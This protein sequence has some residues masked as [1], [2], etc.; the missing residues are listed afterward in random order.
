MAPPRNIRLPNFGWLPRLGLLGRFSVL[1]LAAF[2]LIGIVLGRTLTDQIR[3]RSLVGAGQAAELVTHFG[4]QPQLSSHDVQQGLAPE[5]I[6]SL[7]RLLHAGYTSDSVLTIRIWNL[8]HR[9]VYSDEHTVIGSVEP[10]EPGLMSAIAG[11]TS[12]REVTGSEE[13]GAAGSD[14]SLEAYVPLRFDGDS[15]P[16]GAFEVH[17][18]YGPVAAAIQR[19]TRRLYAV[20]VIGLLVLYGALFRIVAG[21]SRRLRRQAAENEYQAHHDTLTGLPNRSSFYERVG[22]AITRAAVDGEM[23]AVM[24]VDLD[25]FK[26]VNDTLGHHSGDIL[27]KQAA[28]R[29]TAALRPGDALARLGGDEFAVLLPALPHHDAAVAVAARIRDALERP[30]VLH[31][32]TVHID[33]STGIAVFPDHG[34][35]VESLIQRADIA[36]YAAK[37]S[38]LNFEIYAPEEDEHTPGRLQMLGELREAIDSDAFILHYQPKASLRT[39]AVDGVEALVRWEHPERGMVP[40]NDFIPLAE[41]TGLI[42]PLTA[43]VLDAALAQCRQWRDEGIELSIAVNLSVR[44]LLDTHL[45]DAIGALLQK[46]QLPASA[47]QLEITE[48]TIVTDQVRALDVLGRLDGM[49]IGLAIDDFGTGYSSLAYLKDLPVRE[50]KIDRTFV[51]NMDEDGSDAFIV[52]STIDL[53][54]NLGLQVVAEGVETK[55]TLDKLAALGCDLA[56]G[57]YLSRPLP[58]AELRDWLRA[59]REG[60]AAT[61]AKEA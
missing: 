58:A 16:A 4:I 33:A 17:L 59:R 7:D 19:D 28:E 23:A 46:W 21:A 34:A 38:S 53:A 36:M 12:V 24:I 1:S 2:V 41:Q 48:G 6:D 22:R 25:R 3:E 42:K 52:R 15:R 44:N 20:L 49:G 9:V 37:R 5:A 27:L 32:L 40:P 61:A 50:L 45:P 39:G 18:K 54:R 30:F 35:D 43:W 31:G 55:A 10:A 47:L 8:E 29:L 26:E 51:N 14:R 11:R 57:Y 56:Q 13:Y 60:L